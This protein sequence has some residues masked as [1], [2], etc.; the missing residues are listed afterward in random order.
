[1]IL[2]MNLKSSPGV[3]Q[4]Q[5]FTQEQMILLINMKL[6]HRCGIYWPC[7]QE[8]VA[9]ERV[10][11][12]SIASLVMITLMT[13]IIRMTLK[14]LITMKPF[15]FLITLIIRWPWWTW[16]SWL[17]LVIH[18]GADDSINE[19]EIITQCESISIINM[20]A[21]DSINENE[22]ISRCI[23]LSIIHIRAIIILI[24]QKSSPGVY[25][26]QSITQD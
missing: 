22:I 8:I 26:Y 3:Y 16:W 2:S 6:K 20:G 17:L 15:I 9:N 24:N 12:A 14:N 5:S 10:I 4:Y 18:T 1:M 21:D 11:A 13:L 25:L 7:G 23:S 19:S